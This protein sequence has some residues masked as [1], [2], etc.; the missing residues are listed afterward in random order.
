[1]DELRSLRVPADL[2]P[3]FVELASPN[4]AANVETCAIL[5]GKLVGPVISSLGKDDESLASYLW[6]RGGESGE[7]VAV[8]EEANELWVVGLI[9]P[10]QSGTADSCTTCKEEDVFGVLDEKGWLTLGWIHTHP[11]QTV[12]PPLPSPPPS[13]AQAVDAGVPVL[14][15]HAHAGLLPAHAPGGHRHRSLPQVPGDRLLPPH[16]WHRC[17]TTQN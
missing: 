14:C 4:S 15:G 3:A 7:S 1:M 16:P 12:S 8:V 17:K 13:P 5:A 6:K 9:V 10:A 11:S 2:V